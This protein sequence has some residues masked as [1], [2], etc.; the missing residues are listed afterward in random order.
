MLI[1][2]MIL[3]AK[4]LISYQIRNIGLLL[5]SLGY[6]SSH[7]L[8]IERGR[9]VNTNRSDR[10][11]RFC[12]GTCIENEYNFF[13]LSALYKGILEQNILNHTIVDDLMSKTNKNAIL[14]VVKYIYFAFQLRK[15]N[16]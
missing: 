13:C 1:L 5:V 2:N 6:K 4:I 16:L 12:N 8:E 7:D 15:E 10:L 3:C 11:C 14:N 9:H